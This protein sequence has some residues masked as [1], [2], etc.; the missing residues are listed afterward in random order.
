MNLVNNF[1]T[2]ILPMIAGKRAN[3]A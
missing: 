3:R 2:I 1:V